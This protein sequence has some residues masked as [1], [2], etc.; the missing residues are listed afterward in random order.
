MRRILASGATRIPEYLSFGRLNISFRAIAAHTRD[1]VRRLVPSNFGRW[2]TMC[3]C[4]FVTNR[5]ALRNAASPI[6][7]GGAVGMEACY[8]DKCMDIPP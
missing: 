7:S 6:P 1:S 8:P 3:A 2:E 4:A 5:N